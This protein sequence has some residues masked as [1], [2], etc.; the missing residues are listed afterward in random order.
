MNEKDKCHEKEQFLRDDL[1][2]TRDDL[3]RDYL[4]KEN[5]DMLR[6]TFMYIMTE[7]M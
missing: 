3:V 1:F 6:L 5:T 4:F 2:K 7:R